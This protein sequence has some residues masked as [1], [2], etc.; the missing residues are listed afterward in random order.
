[1]PGNFQVINGSMVGENPRSPALTET[2]VFVMQQLNKYQKYACCFNQSNICRYFASV[3]GS[4]R[5][6][7]LLKTSFFS[8]ISRF[9]MS[10]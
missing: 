8:C 3:P 4:L 7:P 5:G 10:F 9:R 1:M 2:P 6:F